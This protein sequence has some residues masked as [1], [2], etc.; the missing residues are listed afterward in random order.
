MSTY[1]YLGQ[2]V[3]IY[4]PVLIL[5]PEV[6]RLADGTRLDSFIKIEGGQGVDIGAYVH[7]SSFCHVNIGGGRVYLGDFSAL[8]SGAR[9][10]G[11]SNQPD[12][13]TMSAAAPPHMQHV[14]R[15]V[16]RLGPYAFLGAGATLMPGVSVGEG[17]VIGAGAVVTK[18]VPAW[19]IWAGVPAKKIG[20]RQHGGQ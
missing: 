12:A 7:I 11:G 5:K 1:G 17:A 20:E 19:E 8:A 4:E 2:G 18:D 14:T 9:I 16:T 6:V 10:L 3:A 13:I 15:A